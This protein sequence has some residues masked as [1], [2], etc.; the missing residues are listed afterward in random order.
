MYNRY[1][2]N[3]GKYYRMED[4]PVTQRRETVPVQHA[5]P[6]PEE[7]YGYR[8]RHDAGKKPSLFGGGG[9]H[10]LDSILPFGLETGDLIL[11][12]LFL[13]LFIE[14]GDEE[15]LIILGFLAFSFFKER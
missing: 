7:Q 9:L 12:I 10:F 15:F 6:K 4:A 8:E 14:S 2:G 13:F 11:L 3:T 5:Q 1:I